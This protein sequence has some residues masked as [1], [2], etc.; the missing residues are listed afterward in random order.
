MADQTA[1]DRAWQALVNVRPSLLWLRDPTGGGAVFAGQVS[2]P[3]SGVTGNL[4]PFIDLM[5][6]EIALYQCPNEHIVQ[7]THQVSTGAATLS[8]IDP[9]NFF[10]ERVFR[11]AWAYQTGERKVR[12]RYGWTNGVQKWPTEPDGGW[13]NFQVS[14][15][16]QTINMDGTRWTMTMTHLGGEQLKNVRVKENVNLT[17]LKIDSIQNWING[18]LGESGNNKQTIM[19]QMFPPD[20]IVERSNAEAGGRYQ[21]DGGGFLGETIRKLLT[22]WKCKQGEH[23]PEMLLSSAVP[24]DQDP[25]TVGAVLLI[26]DPA[27][28]ENARKKN[29]ENNN[30]NVIP[31]FSAYSGCQVMIPWPNPDGGVLQLQMVSDLKWFAMTAVRGISFDREGKIQQASQSISGTPQANTLFGDKQSAQP[32]EA[33]MT[34]GTEPT[35]ASNSTSSSLEARLKSVGD[36]SRQAA[37]II[38]ITTQGEPWFHSF[39]NVMR[40]RIGIMVDEMYNLDRFVPEFDGTN[41]D[42]LGRAFP[43]LKSLS[44]NALQLMADSGLFRRESAAWMNG[45]WLVVGIEHAIQGGNF[46]TKFKVRASQLEDKVV[47]Q[48]RQQ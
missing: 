28:L 16:A 12:L 35:A 9:T 45:V 3:G 13:L 30:R 31:Q 10:L 32:R 8:L 46:T 1:A 11:F 22:Y 34:P 25:S 26:Y 17:D 6:G 4:M 20:G 5:I 24:A 2:S 14:N 15:L 7:F 21:V 47:D 27:F 33:T 44:P 38:E 19:V 39:D 40:M 43:V 18:V 36:F 41:S 29:A 23:S 37:L 48:D 42:E